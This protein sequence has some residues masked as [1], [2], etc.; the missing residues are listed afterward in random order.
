MFTVVIDESGDPGVN[1]VQAD[2]SFGPSQYFTMCA[3]LF[4][5]DNRGLIEDAYSSF[6]WNSSKRKHAKHLGHFDK[7]H[8]C[9]VISE[10]PVA[11]VGVISNKLTL[12][13]YLA[14]AKQTPTHFYNKVTH[15]LLERVGALLGAYSVPKENVRIVFEAR[16]QQYSSLLFYIERIQATPL[17]SNARLLRNIDRF[18]ITTIKKRDEPCM[19]VSDIGAHALFCLLRRDEKM[20]CLT[21]GRYLREL[22]PRFF[23]KRNGLIVDAGLKLIQ[24]LDD[25]T[26]DQETKSLIALLRNPH[27]EYC[28]L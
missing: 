2:P 17:N 5:E 10:L 24:N 27:K 26:S 13:N 22:A 19:W 28:R 16:E 18:S 9:K 23:A 8:A 14:A 12:G 1:G 21:E 4:R 6:P 15:Y 25:V 20:H 7:V 3:T 11:M